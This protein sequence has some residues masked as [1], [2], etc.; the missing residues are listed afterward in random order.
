[1]PAPLIGHDN[2]KRTVTFGSGSDGPT[3]G[4]YRV[5]RGWARAE[6]F[7]G[8]V[9]AA[10]LALVST[11]R[12]VDFAT[13]LATTW[14][15]VLLFSLTAIALTVASTWFLARAELVKH[16]NPVAA[17]RMQMAWVGSLVLAGI[18]LLFFVARMDDSS[19]PPSGQAAARAEELRHALRFIPQAE[20]TVWDRS[21]K[22]RAPQSSADRA[23]CDAITARDDGYRAELKAIEGGTWQTGWTPRDV[24][25]TGHVAGMSDFLRRLLAAMFT[26]LAMAGA[27]VLAQW[28]AMGHAEAFRQADGIVVA[29]A[30]G[31][32][33]SA[34]NPPALISP[35][36]STEMWLATRV[37][38][39][40]G[41]RMRSSDGY[42][43]YLVQSEASGV[44]PLPKPA[45]YRW[46][47][48]RVTAPDLRDKVKALKSNGNTVYDGLCLGTADMGS[49]SS[50]EGDMLALPYRTE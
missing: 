31:P 38:P 43:D 41:M 15:Q 17:K 39:M 30:A 47:A 16:S 2:T 26:L 9:P 19:P 10:I 27:G 7:F 36:E 46:L 25:G 28:A 44:N 23:T 13:D 50:A 22:C 6:I 40:K 8:A 32:S 49:L 35:L 18:A 33:A 24:I 4:S 12:M 45:F 14:G 11:V 21:G 3:E 42:A 48:A 5:A 29:P 37:S 34:G 1:M 20:L